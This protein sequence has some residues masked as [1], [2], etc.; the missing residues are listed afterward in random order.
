SADGT[1]IGTGTLSSGHATLT[2]SFFLAV[3]SH[4]ITASYSGDANFIGSTGSVTQVVDKAGTTTKVTSSPNPTVQIVPVTFTATVSSVA[5]G[6]GMPT[7]TVEFL[8]DG[9]PIGTGTLSSGHATLTPSFFLAVG[10]H[11]ITASYSGDANFNASTGSEAG[12][13]QVTKFNPL[14]G[15]GQS[16]QPTPATTAV[17]PQAAPA[18]GTPALTTGPSG[19]LPLT[20]LPLSRDATAAALLLCVGTVFV[21][22]SK[23]SRTR[24]RATHRARK[25]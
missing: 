19:V 2:P 3:G 16:P 21:L 1:P 7:G 17:A 6:S 10:S 4:A 25:S 12:K 5:P 8:A 14:P 11:A 22:A 15:V 13:Q 24:R 18:T 9:T 20:G 23:R